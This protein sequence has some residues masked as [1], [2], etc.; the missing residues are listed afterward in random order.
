MNVIVCKDKQ[1]VAKKAYELL[2][3]VVASKPNAVLGLATGSSP[4]GLYQEMIADYKANNLSYKDV[5]SFNLDEYVGIDKNHPESY[6]SFMHK[7]L[8]D[9][10]DIVESNTHLPFGSTQEDCDAY[11]ASM[12]NVHIDLQVLG[13]GRNGH[14]GF[15][16]P[17][18][19]FDSLTHIVDLD[20]KTI[21]DNARFFDHDVTLVPKK[22]ISMG[23]ATI[24]KSKEILLIA[25]G[26]NKAD[27]VA[28][29]VNGPVD[30]NV[31]ASILQNHANVNVFVDEA[32]ASKL[33]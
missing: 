23:I 19:S 18:T 27:A 29:M 4:I 15:N 28:A 25:T 8:F 20:E 7:E 1:E 11:E 32:A 5:V 16:E 12:S 33:K 26:E 21:E 24:M 10:I 14:I 9:H 17:G 13:I 6:S 31:P 2:K 3:K 30:E 22:A